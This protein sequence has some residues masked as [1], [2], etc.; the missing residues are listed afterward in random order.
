MKVR[1]GKDN[2]QTRLAKE[3]NARNAAREQ[4]RAALPRH[5][6]RPRRHDG[7]AAEACAAAAA[8]RRSRR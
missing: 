1:T 4:E 2:D 6:A 5:A 7:R 3:V 8:W